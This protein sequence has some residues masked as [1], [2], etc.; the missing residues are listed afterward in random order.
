MENFF[1]YPTHSE[2]DLEWGMVVTA[3]GQ[4]RIPPHSTYPTLQHPKSH[5]FSTKQGRRVT[6]Y[7]IVYITSGGGHFE[8]EN[9]VKQEITTGTA[10]LLF[11]GI[12]HSYQPN[13][14][15][16]WTEYYVGVKGQ[17]LDTMLKNGFI[18]KERPI[19]EIG[20]HEKLVQ[21][22]NEIFDLVKK[23]M[24]GYQQSAVGIVWHLLGEILFFSKNKTI[25]SSTEQL[26]QSVKTSIAERITEKI[27]WQE[28]SKELGVS[29]SKLRKEFKAYMGMSPGQYQ[30]QLR[31]N[32]AKL[33]LSQTIEP[34][35]SIATSLGFQNEY[36]FN[37]IFKRKTGV[38]PGSYRNSSYGHSISK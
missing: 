21:L 22:Y 24:V 5:H 7:Q 9:G 30:I 36:Y 33:M 20:L 27:D 32:N 26:I 37:T 18:S 28:V 23:G 34:I 11:P 10:F 35:K 19:L 3:V 14:E 38:A 2:S 29:Y 16:G 1:N 13:K 4:T 25:D 15:T 31:I 6:E 17:Y 8:S 12:L